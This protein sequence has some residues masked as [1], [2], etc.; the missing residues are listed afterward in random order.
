MSGG[1]PGQMLASLE[2]SLVAESTPAS[3]SEHA[4]LEPST[5]S[6][7]VALVELH[8]TTKT[9]ATRPKKTRLA[10]CEVGESRLMGSSTSIERATQTGD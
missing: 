2:P 8:A 1:A 7:F 5:A 3:H 6:L 10:M 4:S 9:A